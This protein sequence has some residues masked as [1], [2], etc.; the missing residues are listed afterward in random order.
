MGIASRAAPCLSLGT[1]DSLGG[2]TLMMLRTVIP[3]LLASIAFALPASAEDTVSIDIYAIPSRPVVEAVAQASK[4]LAKHGLTT[5][6]RRA[7]RC[8]PRSISPN[9]P[10]APS[11]N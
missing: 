4:D 3:A 6:T 7:M 11:L 2:K 9:I 5:F 8:M 10:P 1:M